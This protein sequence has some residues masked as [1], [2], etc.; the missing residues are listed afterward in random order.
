MNV[1]IEENLKDLLKK[2]LQ[3]RELNN[4]QKCLSI[5]EKI[6]N[7]ISTYDEESIYNIISGV[8]L[9]NHQSNYVK[10]G[11]LY[12]MIYNNYNDINKNINFKKKFYQLL[13][14]SLKKETKNDQKS[15]K[16]NILKFYESSQNQDFKSL[17][18]YLLSLKNIFINE[19]INSP[20]N[21]NLSPSQDEKK[22]MN[23]TNSIIS[24]NLI[25]NRNSIEDDLD[26][27][28]SQ[29]NQIT[30]F[31]LIDEL[32]QN[33]FDL[34]SSIQKV[35][36]DQK[37]TGKDKNFE[38][39]YKVNNKLPMIVAS[40]SINLN[41]VKFLE[42]IDSNFTKLKYR[43]I[44]N[45]KNSVYNTINIYEYN[46]KNIFEKMVYCI[47]IKK[48][49]IK[50]IFQV[51]TILKK[52]E[53]N[54]KSGLNYFLNDTYERK[55]AIKTIKGNE[56]NVSN[57]IVKYFNALAPFINKIK[58]T[59]QSKI[60]AQFNLEEE[61]NNQIKIRH[62]TLL[63][64]FNIPKKKNLISIEEE[65]LVE[66]TNKKVNQFYEI[67]KVLS[68]KEYELGKSIDIF[69]TDIKNKIKEINEMS[70]NHIEKFDT[71]KLMEEIIKIIESST[72][73][74]N[75]NFNNI[76]N[77]YDSNFYATASEQFIFNKIYYLLYSLYEKK[78]QKVN[79]EYLLI[80]KDIN[81]IMSIKDIMD[82][83]G[84]DKRYK[85]DEEI[86]YNNVIENLNKIPYEKCLKN[87]F[88]ILTQSSMELRSYILDYTNGKKELES[89]DDELP[90]IIYIVTQ[91]NVA[92]FFAE[93][94][95]VDDYVKCRL[96][97]DLNQNKMVTNLLSSLMFIS[98]SWDQK[99]KKFIS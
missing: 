98:K 16:E 44:A 50:N 67:Y 62:E 78:Y 46:P 3:Y 66:K 41:S 8:L 12:Y 33:K 75:S 20:S 69:L 47:P 49:F 48:H 21:E 39:R 32:K 61:I 26:P 76:N 19:N 81:D 18:D 52:D 88:E 22:G 28:E 35:S 60:I 56:K 7:S 80:K 63:N 31:G 45:I 24:N 95:M 65:T 14:D 40:V 37:L 29:I 58:I 85:G 23:L 92:N 90:I 89:M 9:S 97:D 30:R 53:N 25:S 11:V 27:D 1:I 83:I 57:F 87:K 10:I 2:E 38:K 17:D 79:E 34:N 68:N 72:N 77:I 93:L 13:I 71:K 36:I 5:C 73:S 64:N 91:V 6:L 59:K 82:N 43:K 84:V 55:I 15:E 99:E 4:S 86:P 51:S 42:L 74:L 96:R 70:A 54:F 94:N